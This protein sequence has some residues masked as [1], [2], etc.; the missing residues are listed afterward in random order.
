[1]PR[2]PNLEAIAPD[3]LNW[4]SDYNKNLLTLGLNNFPMR[5]PKHIG[6]ETDITS[7]FPPGR[8]S[9]C[10][11]LVDDTSNGQSIYLCDGTAWN[12]LVALATA[13]TPSVQIYETPV[14]V[15]VQNGDINFEVILENNNSVLGKANFP[16]SFP[17]HT[18][19]ETDLETL[20]PAID[21]ENCSILVY[22]TT[23]GAS[24]YTSDGTIWKRQ[25]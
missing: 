12:R 21:W 1:M 6:D 23:L 9:H 11:L 14:L 5:L 7:T 16:M 4:D 2:K 13:I 24:L 8:W 22:N 15:E 25:F 10:I 3:S 20:L 19:D 18:G 17:A